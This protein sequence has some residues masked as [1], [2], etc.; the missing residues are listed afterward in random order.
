[1]RSDADRFA[2]IIDAIDRIDR[3]AGTGRSAFDAD[4]LVQVWV[5][6]HL[7]IIGESANG[8][9]DA[10]RHGLP[11]RAGPQPVVGVAPTV[12]FE[13][14]AYNWDQP[15]D[16][17]I[18]V[19]LIADALGYADA[20]EAPIAEV[21][22]RIEAL[23]E[24]LGDRAAGLTV[25]AV[26]INP[27]F[28]QLFPGQ[29]P[30]SALLE[31]L[32][33][34]RPTGQ[35]P[36]DEPADFSLELIP[37]LDGDVLIVFGIDEGEG[38]EARYAEFTRNRSGNSSARCSVATCTWSGLARGTT[39]AASSRCTPSWT[40]WRRSSCEPPVGLDDPARGSCSTR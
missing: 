27:E 16:W 39:P 5:V 40:T 19:R 32:G 38:G 24:R 34:Q 14:V 17:Q 2:D 4:E 28:V 3:H 25:S 9:S 15:T 12:V 8:L 30:G 18:N 20:V 23:R 10:A 29:G 21:D 33:V 7:Q 1:M 22:A 26:R 35:R 36:T 31:Q 6:R 13:N 11:R 37:Q